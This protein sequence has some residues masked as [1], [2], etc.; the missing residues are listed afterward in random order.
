[1]EILKKCRNLLMMHMAALKL[2][3]YILFFSKNQKKSH[4]YSKYIWQMNLAMNCGAYPITCPRSYPTS[5]YFITKL[6]TLN[7]LFR[8]L[9]YYDINKKLR[10]NNSAY[11]KT[12]ELKYFQS[13]ILPKIRVPFVLV[14]GASDYST[15][16]FRE[17]LKNKYLL[18]WFAQHNNIKNK[19]ITVL[20]AGIDFS[21]LLERTYFSEEQM[22]A[23]EQEGRLE[24]V[25]RID[26]K[27]KLKIFTNFHLNYTNQRR[28][29][30]HD[31]LRNN[32]IIYFQKTKMSRTEMWKLQKG[33]AFNF[34]PAGN[35]LDAYRTWESL[36]LGQIPIVEKLGTDID[37]LHKE[38]PI[39][40]IEDVSEINEKNL[41]KW[42]K[43]YSKMFNADMEKRLTNGYWNGLIKSERG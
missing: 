21:T 3:A 30:L 40:V 4:S 23:Q 18:H 39:V 6:L 32:S 1:M 35:G 36:L 43:K 9:S 8:F 12:D 27:K 33:F 38:F 42:Y 16:K 26:S 28:K 17:I 15:S 11:V 13:T 5:D 22:T 29:E 41:R 31:L 7:Y 24:K 19:K 2:L 20:P 37:N 14:T 25:R 34:S 10:K